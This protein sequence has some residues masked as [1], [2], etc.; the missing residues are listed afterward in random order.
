MTKGKALKTRTTNSNMKKSNI[1]LTTDEVFDL[2]APVNGGGIVAEETT[3]PTISHDQLLKALYWVH[4]FMDRANINFYVVGK[5]GDAVKGRKDL[6]GDTVQVA[7]RE[8]E[9]ISGARN[10]ADAFATPIVDR[11]TVVEYEYEGVPITLYVLEDSET[12]RNFDTQIYL[13]EYFKLPNT[14]DKFKEEFPWLK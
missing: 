8:L 1:V 9:W 14:F 3:L 2:T 4:D 13:N 11:G 10:I 5:T 12:L 7:V 6:T